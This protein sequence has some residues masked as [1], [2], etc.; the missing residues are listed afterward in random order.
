MGMEYCHRQKLLYITCLMKSRRGLG[1]IDGHSHEGERSSSKHRSHIDQYVLNV[2]SYP[3]MLLAIQFME[4]GQ[5]SINQL[6]I[7][8]SNFFRIF[9]LIISKWCDIKIRVPVVLLSTRF[10]YS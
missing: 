8:Q 10:R 2:I 7:Y 6:S 3:L 1:L 4:L 5:L 9:L